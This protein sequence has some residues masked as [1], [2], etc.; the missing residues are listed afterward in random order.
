MPA[1][2]Y[3]ANKLLDHQ[4][5]KTSFTMPTA[6]HIGLSTTTPTAAGTNVTEPSGGG[7]ARV[8]TSGA[9]WA[10]A[11]AGATSNANAITFPEASSTWLSGANFTHVVIYDASTSGNMLSFGAITVAKSATAGDT[12]SIAPGELDMT[13]S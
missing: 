3:L 6:V 5:G 2:T 12:L 10:A 11:S 1:S 4:N 9:T 13:L 8:T 7:Y